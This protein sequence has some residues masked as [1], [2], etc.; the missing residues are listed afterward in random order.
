[1]REKHV[2]VG[3][4]LLV[5]AMT[6]GHVLQFFGDAQLFPMVQRLIDG[7][8]LLVFPSFVFYFGMTAALAYLRRPYAAALPGMLRTALRAYGAFALSGIGYRVLRENRALSP[9]AVRRVLLLTDI[10]GWSEFLIA[11][12][13]YSLLLAAGFGLFARLAARPRAALAAGALCLAACLIPYERVGSVRL[14]LLIGGTAYSYFPV[15][16]YMPYFLAGLV[17]AQ[18]D[19][20]MRRRMA[21][22]AAVCTAAGSLRALYHG[23]LPSRFP[24]HWAWIALPALAVA[25]LVLLS[26]AL[27]SQ[28]KTPLQWA[29]RPVLALLARLGGMSLFALVSGNLALFTL[30]GRGIVPQLA[31]AGLPP[32]TLP[33]QS[34]AGALCWTAAL[35]ALIGFLA[36]LA[37]RGRK[38]QGG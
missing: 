20:R 30:A 32:W 24:P 19:T 18:A 11:F 15:V 33:I 12:A 37:G 4:G 27:C 1:M 6:Y 23:A 10:P 13:I 8:N 2:D 25:G 36:M 14:S 34:P 38:A 7:I 5:V 29:A 22:L 21:A 16:Q 3:R 28:E 26:R 35:L 31:R 17:F 9:A